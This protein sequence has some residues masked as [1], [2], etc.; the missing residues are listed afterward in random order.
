MDKMEWVMRIEEAIVV[1]IGAPREP[2]CPV[3]VVLDVKAV[4]PRGVRP[5]E[6]DPP[7]GF[8]PRPLA[9]VP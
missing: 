6:G 4:E 5:R 9:S 1:V 2:G 8:I 3:W 7:F